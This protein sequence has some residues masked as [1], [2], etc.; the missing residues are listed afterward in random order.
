MDFKKICR[1]V[2]IL[3]IWKRFTDLNFFRRFDKDLTISYYFVDWKKICRFLIFLSTWKRLLHLKLF[4][5]LKWFI[6]SKNTCGYEKYLPIWKRVVDLKNICW[7]GEYIL[8]MTL[9]GH[10]TFSFSLFFFYPQLIQTLSLKSIFD[11]HEEENLT[12]AIIQFVLW[13]FMLFYNESVYLLTCV[14]FTQSCRYFKYHTCIFTGLKNIHRFLIYLRITITFVDL[15]LFCGFEKDLPIWT[16]YVDLTKIWRF[17]IILWI[18]KRFA[19]FWFSCRFEKDYSIWNFFGFEND[20]FIQ[21]T[22]ADMKNIFRF[23]K[24][25]SIWKNIC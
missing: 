21:K 7:F 15:S 2:I 20:L 5:V 8:W 14:I 13:K 17:L 24:E 4:H 22:L 16:F 1:F 3:W 18:W 10:R 9:L 23:E 6:H 19:D 25:L 12:L 11:L